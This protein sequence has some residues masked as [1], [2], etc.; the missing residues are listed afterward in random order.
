MRQKSTMAA[1]QNASAK[2]HRWRSFRGIEWRRLSEARL[3]A[4]YALQWLGRAG[5]AYIAPQPDY[6][7]TN[8]GW[9]DAFDGF[10]THPFKDGA[11]L[12]L[13]IVDLTLV[14]QGGAEAAR[15]QSLPL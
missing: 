3:Q 10:T 9:D 14:L 7:H 12:S 4:H 1:C 11:W 6:G 2:D 8:L 15:V 5:S 13:K